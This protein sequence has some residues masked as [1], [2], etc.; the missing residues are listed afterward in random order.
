M[1]KK[2]RI[3]GIVTLILL[4]SSFCMDR[5]WSLMNECRE[6]KLGDYP[7]TVEIPNTTK[8]YEDYIGD[9]REVMFS[10][11]LLDK[12]LKYWGYIQLWNIEELERFLD[13]S[14]GTSM[15]NFTYYRKENITVNT[16]RGFLV[17]WS[18][19][20]TND[21]TIS[22]KEYFLKKDE[23]PMVLRISFLTNDERF[24]KELDELINKV[25]FSI[26]W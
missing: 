7:I 3:I 16:Y 8:V 6:Y 24:P 25:L 1:T 21:R 11:H 12:K 10:A 19:K 2:A 26:K 22:A 5:G 4:M 14:K 13:A 9:K 20:F 18:A 17:E 15:Y 23:G